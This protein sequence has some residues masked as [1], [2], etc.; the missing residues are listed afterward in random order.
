MTKKR[1]STLSLII[2]IASLKGGGGKSNIAANLAVAFH[3]LGYTVAV[4]DADLV[5]NTTQQW[6]DDREEYMEQHPDSGIALI[7]VV[8]KTGKLG[9]T[10]AEQA[11]IYNVVIIDTGSQDSSEM[12]SALGHVTVTLTPVEATQEA[13]DG[14]KPLV[15]IVDAARDFN[16]NL[17]LIAVLSRV[18]PNSPKRIA[19]ASDYIRTH[20]YLQDFVTEGELLVADT[21]VTQRVAHPDSK[22]NGLTGVESKDAA[23]KAEIEA[24]AHELLTI[25]KEN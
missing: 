9:G 23:A 21:V 8:K 4:I 19:D 2:E 13:L 24:L 3:Q 11:A 20:E 6:H 18:Q 12:R 25:T 14:L 1:E 16:E 10:I 5:M 15:E 17:K 22:A 7:P